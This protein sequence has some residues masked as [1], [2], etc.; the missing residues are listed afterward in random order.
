MDPAK[1]FWQSKKFWMTI[2]GILA[3]LL[4]TVMGMIPKESAIYGL[5]GAVAAV[6]SYVTAQGKVDAAN[7]ISSNQAA[8][9][10]APKP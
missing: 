9:P 4:P 5:L 2:A 1:P 6:I 3:V 8:A 10:L 7:A